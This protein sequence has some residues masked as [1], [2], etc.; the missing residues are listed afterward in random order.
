MATQIFFIATP[1]L[2]DDVQFDEHIFQMGWELN[3]QLGKDLGAIIQLIANDSYESD[4]HQV[5]GKKT[6]IDG[7]FLVTTIGWYYRNKAKAIK[8][9]DTQKIPSKKITW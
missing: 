3:H 9:W 1:N 2:G 5:P 6:L 4:G 8:D 7:C